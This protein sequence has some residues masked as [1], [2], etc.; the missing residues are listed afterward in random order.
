MLEVGTKAPDFYASGPERYPAQSFPVQ[1]TEGHS[2][3]LPEGHDRRLHKTGLRLCGE[4]SAVSGER[5]GDSRR[6]QGQR[7]LS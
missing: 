5:R 1:R 6:Q 2:V 7:G 4:I 3:F